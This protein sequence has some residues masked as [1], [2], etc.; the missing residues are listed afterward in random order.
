[1]IQTLEASFDIAFYEPR[2]SKPVAIYF[3]ESRMAS[4]LWAKAMRAIAELWLV[5]RAED[6]AND[7]LQQL[8]TPGRHAERAL[9]GRVLF[10]DV[11]A[12]R[13][14][15]SILFISQGFNDVIDFR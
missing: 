1:M 2:G 11:D 10:L 4:S 13:R 8:I 3:P 9:L 7:F 12:P 14:C 15:P 5:I 6:Q